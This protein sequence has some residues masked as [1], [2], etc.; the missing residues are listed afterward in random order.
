[1]TKQKIVNTGEFFEIRSLPPQYVYTE[2][3]GVIVSIFFPTRKRTVVFA[4]TD[5]CADAESTGA[6]SLALLWVHF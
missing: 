5:L 1:M 3:F 2:V 6:Y 4:F